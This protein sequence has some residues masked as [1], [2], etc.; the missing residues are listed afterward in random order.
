MDSRIQYAGLIVIAYLFIRFIIKMFSYQTRVIETMTASTM[1]NPSIATSVSANTD[2]LNDTLLISKYRTNYE[3][4]IIQ[5]EKAISIAVLSEVVN[6]A[7]TISSD[8]I[9]SDS[10]KAI[11]N[12]N[13]LKNFRESLNQSMIIL[14][15]N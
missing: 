1:D 15:K 4:T 9:S 5:L 14:D 13:Q 7:V 11:A 6:N 10:L 2:K 12:I 3:D 8:P